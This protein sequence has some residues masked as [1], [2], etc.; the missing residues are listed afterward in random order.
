[1]SRISEPSNASPTDVL[2]SCIG[3]FRG[4]THPLR[5]R[6]FFP[7]FRAGRWTARFRAGL[8]TG[9]S[10]A[11]AVSKD[12]RAWNII[13]WI[14]SGCANGFFVPLTDVAKFVIG[15]RPNRTVE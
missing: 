12:R 9:S 10:A 15:T 5:R 2:I 3:A 6:N 8:A 1:M 13:T 11:A 14:A 7:S 4:S